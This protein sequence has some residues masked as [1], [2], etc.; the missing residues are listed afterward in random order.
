MDEVQRDFPELCQ[1]VAST[2]QAVV[3]T[4]GCQP[5]V[6]IV[7]VPRASGGERRSIWDLRRQFE[8]SHGAL[9]ED[10]DLPSREVD[11]TRWKDPF[12]D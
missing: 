2:G 4:R 7:P 12:K 1:A 3:V 8:Q 6:S 10:L 11:E 5:L 9:T